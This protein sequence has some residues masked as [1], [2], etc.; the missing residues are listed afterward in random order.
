MNT[1]NKPAIDPKKLVQEIA[2]EELEGVIGGMGEEFAGGIG[3]Q[4]GPG[5]GG[6]GDQFAGYPR[7]M[8]AEV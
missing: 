7:R 5:V 1:K 8:S 3:G 4:G 2:T 6:G